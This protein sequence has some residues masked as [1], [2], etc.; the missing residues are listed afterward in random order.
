VGGTTEQCVDPRTIYLPGDDRFAISCADFPAGVTRFAISATADPT[1]SWYLYSVPVPLDQDTIL[2]TSDKFVVAGRDL[3][4]GAAGTEVFV[5]NKGDVLAG[6]ASPP[7]V[8]LNAPK[9]VLYKSAVEQTYTSNGYLVATYPGE[10]EWIATISGTPAAADVSL[11]ETDLGVASYSSPSEPSVPGGT[12]GGGD[13][14]GR[15]YDAVYEVDTTD[16]KAIIEYSS[17]TMCGSPLR[18]CLAY[19]RL[20]LS[21][22]T[23]VRTAESSVGAAGWDYTY[24][25]AGLDGAGNTYLAY[26][27]S[28]ATNSPGAGVLGQGFDVALQPGEAGG[29]SCEPATSPP[30]DERWGDYLGTAIDPSDPMVV[31]VTG[32]YQLANSPFASGSNDWGTVVAAVSAGPPI[33]SITSI[34][35]TSGPTQGGVSVDITGQNLEGATSVAFGG[36]SA[37]FSLDSSTKLTATA[38]PHLLGTVDVTVATPRGQSAV[39]GS[40]Q[41]TYA[42]PVDHQLCYAA[43]GTFGVPTAG[44]TLY[45]QFN[46]KG[47]T[48]QISKKASLL[49]N[50]VVKKLT[51]TG[52]VFG[53]TNSRAH[54][55]CF[56][57]TAR[58]TAPTK[59]LLVSNQFGQA[60]LVVPGNAANAVCVPSWKSL[61]SP[62]HKAANTPPGLNHFTCYPVAVNAGAYHPPP[63]LLKD[64]FTQKKVAVQVNPAPQELCLPAKKVIQSRAGNHVYPVVNPTLHLLCFAVTKTPIRNAVYAQNQFG[65]AKMRVT[66]TKWLCLPSTK[67]IVG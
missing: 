48:P 6:T 28:N 25:A 26:S 38:P 33:P 53:V 59:T 54:L 3:A 56:P 41:F 29:S 32:L 20:D 24:G 17:A 49:C 44:V 42:P 39:T 15:T 45:D 34:S 13:L 52:Q 30:C 4:A 14:D 64:E 2:A 18:N 62:L 55:V 23:P 58:N 66:R 50:P 11:T 19:G 67:Q 9:S 1:G 46:P 51:A 21:G 16:H 7:H 61:T 22:A 57:M 40:D 65:S 10:H 43:S 5:F 36:S 31:W 35:P 12:L 27:R 47:F 37:A 60:D 63:I 8:H